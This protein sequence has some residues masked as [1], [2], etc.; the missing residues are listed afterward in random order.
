[1]QKQGIDITS[2]ATKASLTGGFRKV[3]QGYDDAL[4]ELKK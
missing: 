1:M 4:E 3:V 2:T